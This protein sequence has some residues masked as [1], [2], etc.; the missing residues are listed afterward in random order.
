MKKVN[1]LS[2]LAAIV[3][4]GLTLFFRPF[5]VSSEAAKVLAV[6]ALMIILWVSEA[7]SMPVVALLPLIMFPL[8]GI[9]KIE[10]AAQ[11][12]A[13]PIIFLFMGRADKLY[14]LRNRFCLNSILAI[15]TNNRL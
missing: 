11:P 15:F 14:K 10:E 12:Y 6:A 3:L 1:L 7:L 2:F 4:F 9:C 5:C 8:L 13:S